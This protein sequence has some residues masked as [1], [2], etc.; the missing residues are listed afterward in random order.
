M[1]HNRQLLSLG[2]LLTITL[3]FGVQGCSKKQVKKDRDIEETT[4]NAEGRRMEPVEIGYA[5]GMQRVHFGF[6]Q[7]GLS[8]DLRSVLKDNAEWLKENRNIQ[9][10]VEGHCDSRGTQQYNLALGQKRADAVVNYLVDLGVSF[11]RLSTVSYG[12]EQPVDDRDD[13]DAWTKN[14]RADFKITD[15]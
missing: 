6:D 10:Q 15:K 7:Y 9:I 1:I 4:I 2:L 14:R 11:S 8:S 12:E 3:F 13:E 5:G